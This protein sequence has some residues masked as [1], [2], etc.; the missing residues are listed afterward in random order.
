[1]RRDSSISSPFLPTA[2][3]VTPSKTQRAVDVPPV[4]GVCEDT[5]KWVFSPP[6]LVKSPAHLPLGVCMVATGSLWV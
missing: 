3:D 6:C 5:K 4:F 1:M 2:F